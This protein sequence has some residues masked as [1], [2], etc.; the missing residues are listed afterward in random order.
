MD[1][2]SGG[3]N[4]AAVRLNRQKITCAAL[5]LLDEIGL[6]ALSTRVLAT[7]LGA[8]PVIGLL[9]SPIWAG[10]AMTFSAVSGIVNALRLRHVEL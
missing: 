10:A 5:Q 2:T 9:I 3:Q 8:A 7:R 1:G 4:R 6:D